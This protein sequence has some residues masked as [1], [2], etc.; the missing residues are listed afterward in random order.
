MVVHHF[1]QLEA[2][3][4]DLVDLVCVFDV[5]AD[6]VVEDACGLDDPVW[7]RLVSWIS[8]YMRMYDLVYVPWKCNAH[9]VT[10]HMRIT[11]YVVESNKIQVKITTICA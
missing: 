9:W 5:V 3:G 8:G 7:L 10:N 4:A 1:M 2:H 11:K 6:L